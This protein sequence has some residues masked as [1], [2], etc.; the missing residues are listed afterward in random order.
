M[1]WDFGKISF[2]LNADISYYI[3]EHVFSSW[4]FMIPISC[5]DLSTFLWL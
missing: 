3:F 5:S 2:L 4:N 1:Y